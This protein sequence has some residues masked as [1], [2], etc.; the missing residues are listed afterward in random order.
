[1]KNIEKEADAYYKRNGGI[2]AGFEND[3]FQKTLRGLPG[4]TALEIGCLDGARLNDLAKQ[5]ARTTD[6]TLQVLQ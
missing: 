5:G 3:L 4:E 6:L 1:M 2:A